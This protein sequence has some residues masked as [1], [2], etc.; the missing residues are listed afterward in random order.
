MM[1]DV[2]KLPEVQAEL[3]VEEE[4]QYA[5]DAE[6]KYHGKK[7]IDELSLIATAFVLL[8]AGYDTTG[9]T[10]AYAA[11]E[12]AKNPDIQKRL[13]DEVDDAFQ[14]SGGKF[15]DFYKIQSMEYLDMVFHETLRKYP[16]L[17][18]IQRGVTED[19]R[20]VGTDIVYPKGDELYINVVGI[21]HDPEYYPE[22]EK[23]N[24]EHFSKENK[25]NRHPWDNYWL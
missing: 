10:L 12:L 4:D 5:K 11:F 25:A 21:H 8:V 2:I 9:Q 24:P 19:Y 18:M 14:E 3:E 1:L 17:S 20:I 23:F 7:K 6:I 15:P 16:A 22:P 13:Q